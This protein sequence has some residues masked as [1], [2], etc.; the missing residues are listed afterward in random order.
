LGKWKTDERTQKKLARLTDHIVSEVSSTEAS[1]A[2]RRAVD[3]VKQ[4]NGV[5]GAERAKE[6]GAWLEERLQSLHSVGK[7]AESSAPSLGQ[8]TAR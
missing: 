7:N 2:E 3:V 8:T 1:E 6:F 5:L 4:L